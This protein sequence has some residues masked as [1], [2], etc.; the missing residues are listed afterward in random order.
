VNRLIGLL[1]Y[2]WPLKIL[3]FALAFLLYAGLVVSQST[4]EYP[5]S[6]RIDA[7]NRPTDAVV[8]GNLP[9]VTRIRYVVNG[10]VGAGPTADTWRATI[11]LAGVD[12]QAGSIY[13]PVSVTSNDPRFLVVD[14]E[15]RGITV[16]LDPFK[17]YVVPVTVDTGTAPSGLEVEAPTL[18]V[19]T[20]TVSGPDSIVKFVV[21]AKAN[22]AIDPQGLFVDRDVPLIPVD[23]QDNE[24]R[25]V[26]VEPRTVHV[27][28]PVFS[29][30]Q[31]KS[32]VVNPVVTGTP[33]NGYSVGTITV[34]PSTILAKGDPANLAAV[35]K[36]DTA[37]I[38]V[39]AATSTIATDVELALP[40][41]ILAVDVRT[42]HVTVTIEPEVGTRT[43]QV[44]LVPT[45]QQPGMTYS[46]SV[47]NVLLSI[48][49]PIA[50]LDRLDA[51]TFTVPVDVSRLAPGTYEIEPSPV[52][53]AGLRLLRA[54]PATVT[55]TVTAGT[56]VKFWKECSWNTKNYSGRTA[57]AASRMSISSPR[58]RTRSAGP[59]LT[60][61]SARAAGWSSARTPAVP[62]TCSSRRSPPVRRASAATC[63]SRA[64]SRRRP[65]RSSPEPATSLPGSWSRPPTTPPTT[66]A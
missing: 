19:K 50:D 21:E 51:A 34:E 64:A 55:V 2:N 3:A 45:G 7:I 26:R 58:S 14:Y 48:G 8:L 1:V 65:W 29:N 53:Q 33:P 40:E 32:L 28:I 6:V 44:G 35:I 18:S 49:G 38:P 42:V 10:D 66:T 30:A 9:A 31:T 25:N 39:G 57:S 23:Q 59:R 47:L 54:D 56:G 63:G 4:F 17:S 5:G 11:D 20:V 15:P 60:A 61:S 43:F 52:L 12:P 13:R 24:V 27:Q 62:A 22:V 37:P 41:G 36:A 46:L 16:Q